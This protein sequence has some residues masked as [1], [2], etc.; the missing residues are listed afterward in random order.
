MKKIEVHLFPEKTEKS[1]TFRFSWFRLA[2]WILGIGV[3]LAGFVA[4]SPLSLWE[5]ISDGRLIALYRQNKEIKNTIE[6]LRVRTVSTQKQLEAVSE[7][8][9]TAL[10]LG[11]VPDLDSV[12]SFK[13]KHSSSFAGVR[14][15][16]RRFLDSL[17]AHPK[18]AAALPLLHPLKNHSQVTNRF[19]IIYDHFTEQKLP[20]RGI[21]FSTSEGDTV[22]APG[23][24]IVSE[25]RSH[26]GF[27]LSLKL[28]HSSEIKTF[29]A[30]LEKTLVSK[31]SRVRRGDPIAISG[32]S[33][34]ISGSA[35]HYELRLHGEPINPEDFFITP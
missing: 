26:R 34:V 24:G 5:K 14:Q 4:F 15:T 22:I 7:I 28:D 1:K 6:E 2:A 35:L 10:A 20:H 3:A 18:K 12:L 17:E 27:G 32:K 13:Q 19:Q 23:E 8:R 25:I 11:G 31:G 16:F 30:H 29:F 21:D 33:G 9:N